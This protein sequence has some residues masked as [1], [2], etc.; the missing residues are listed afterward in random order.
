MDLR[1]SPGQSYLV[2][3]NRHLLIARLQ[4]LETMQLAEP[5]EPGVWA[6]SPRL[7]PALKKLGHRIDTVDLMQKALGE[8]AAERG[9]SNFVIHREMPRSPITGHLRAKGLASDGLADKVHLVIDGADG[10]VHYVE[11]DAAIVPEDARVGA[12]LSVGKESAAR[13]V[14]KTVAALAAPTTGSTSPA[15]MPRSRGAPSAFPAAMSK[16]TLRRT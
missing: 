13:S 14:D 5:V 4:K 9:V 6:L 12:I 2:R 16:G 3:A 1:I 10:R 15:S 7:E 8:E 11:L